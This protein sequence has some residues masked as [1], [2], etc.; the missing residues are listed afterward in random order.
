MTLERVVVTGLGVV[1]CIGQDPQAFWENLVNG[2]SGI[3]RISAFDPAPYPTQIAAEV[4]DFAMAGKAAKRMDRFSQFAVVSAQQAMDMAGLGSEAE[5][6]GIDP[7][8]IGVALGTG[9][10][11]VPFLFNEHEKFLQ[12]GLKGFHPLTVPVV[13]SNMAAANVSMQLQLLGPNLCISTA[14]ATGNHNI[15]AALD[16]IRLGRADVMVAGS[17]ESTIAP[18]ALSG[19]I[20]LRALSTRN[21]AP[22]QASRPFS[23]HRDGF[24]LGEGAGV[25]VLES[26]RHAQARGATILAEVLGAGQ[27]ADGYHLTAPHPEGR[28]AVAAMQ[29]ALADAELNPAA[30][31]YIN[32]HGTSTSLNDALETQAIKTV[33]GEAARQIPVSSI[34]SMVGHSLGAAAGIEAVACVQAIQHGVIPPTINLDEPDPALDLDYVPH[35]AREADLQTVVSNAFAFGGQNAVVV[36]GRHG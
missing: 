36:F 16:L 13:I 28:G 1:S 19:Y 10:G 24:V 5:R 30:V 25:L 26:L 21:D 8:R 17:T 23:L 29:M 4:R 3:D 32:A 33:F 9:I 6:A 14:C 7:M 12:R 27:S 34:K 2:R 15:A 18:F 35:T 22:Q 11:G 20:Q 31:S